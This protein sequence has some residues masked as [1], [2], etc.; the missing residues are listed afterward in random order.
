MK[1][2][3]QRLAWMAVLLAVSSSHAGFDAFL[4]IEGVDGEAESK[5]DKHKGWIEVSSF[6]SPFRP[7]SPV[8]P[9]ATALEFTKPTDKSS[10][11]LFSR[12]AAGTPATWARLELVQT[13]PTVVRV[14]DIRMSNVL[15][16]AASVMSDPSASDA[17]PTESLSLNFTKI[18]W[19][20]TMAR[21]A[22]RLPLELRSASWNSATGIGTGSTNEAMFTVT[23]IRENAGNVLLNWQ[24][25][26][27]R[28][29]DIYACPSLDGPFSF[30]Y[31]V[32]ATTNGPMS[33]T[34]PLQ[35]GAMFFA[36]EERP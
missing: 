13:N 8:S 11:V 17:R 18:E 3:L 22:T 24:G 29:Y 21:P 9:T 33:H 5:S 20:Y 6:S 2:L 30:Q 35:P 7:G 4:K 19:T 10:P 31:Q 26:A 34:A 12:C 27:G 28:T 1:W 15:V 16:T 36:V 32:V 23:G 25:V 14:F